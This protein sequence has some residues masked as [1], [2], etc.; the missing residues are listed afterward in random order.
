MYLHI[1]TNAAYL[2]APKSRRRIVAYFYLGRYYNDRT[3]SDKILNVAIHVECKLLQNIVSSATETET[4]GIYINYQVTI[5]LRH[6]LKFVGYIQAPT[7][8]KTD[9]STASEYAN[10]TL[11]T[12]TKQ[13]RDM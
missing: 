7:P 4:G 13:K 12:K 3:N 9:K 5:P 1:D 11:K 10:D 2:T 6:M 8:A